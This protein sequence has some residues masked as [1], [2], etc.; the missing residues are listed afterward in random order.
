VTATIA[1]PIA[2]GL[3]RWRALF[4]GAIALIGALTVGGYL[5]EHA[6]TERAFHSGTVLRE[7]TDAQR[8]VWEAESAVR[9]QLLALDPTAR[10]RY[11]AAREAA[12]RH[13][14]ALDSLT[15]DNTDQQR[16]VGALRAAIDTWA[17]A[18]AVPTFQGESTAREIAIA[19]TAAFDD[20]TR[21]FDEVISVETELQLERIARRNRV[22]VIVLSVL[23]LALLGAAIAFAR[24]A[25]ALAAAAMRAR[26]SHQRAEEQASELQE[27]ASQ[28]EEQAA[29]LEEQ[30]AELE[31]RVQVADEANAQLEQ[32]AAFL[33]S[34]LDGAPMGI[35]FYDRDLRFL[36]INEALA[37]INGASAEAHIGRSIE[38]MV[39][40]IAP[41]VRP[42]IEHVLRTNTTASDVLVEGR[43]PGST[44]GSRRWLVTYYPILIG[45]RENKPMGVGCMVLDVTERSQLEAQ[46]RQAQKMEAVGR[47]AGGIA[48]DFNNVLTIIQ[49]YAELLQ[50]DLGDDGAGRAEVGA[51][52]SAADRATALA[53]QLLAFSRREVV[54][55]R[56]L[57]VNTVIRGMESILRRLLRQGITLELALDDAP[58]VVRIDAGQLE[59]VLMN[60][61]INAVDAMPNGG[62]LRIETAPRDHLPQADADRAAP[63]ALITVRDTG[64]GM[65]SEVQE[66]LFEPFFTTKPAGQGTGLGL[67]TTY[68][69]VHDAGGTIRLQSALGEGSTFDVFLPRAAAADP[70]PTRRETPVGGMPVARAGETLLLAED[71]PAIREALARMLRAAG[72]TVIEASNGGEA[73]R[74]AE[75]TPGRIDLLLTDVMM[76][77]VGGKELVQRLRSV[78]PETRV[79]LMSGY[80]DDEA[81]R[82]EL[83]D[84]RH[85]FLQK[86]FAAR[87]AVT[88][89]RELLDAP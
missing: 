74:R 12:R 67:A 40:A 86:P 4:I 48:H 55:P 15:A 7:L 10:E 42:I 45:G 61:A 2:L 46:L 47:L 70:E 78:R 20:V 39:P 79:I 13:L 58:L 21:L 23:L 25:G 50:S 41:T 71:E 64:T 76:P 80:T 87:K 81:L 5:I 44:S 77:G 68:A 35:A 56:D 85:V 59:Q 83:G 73:L 1:D 30:A 88:A 60:L 65:T 49:S 84:A 29:T 16:R 31:H 22:R 62:V 32:T 14:G 36:R 53:R 33:D 72:F 51:I 34:A 11:T 9:A 66:R 89:V 27:Q 3:Q 24:L 52:R 37:R 6:S 57:D 69:I 38:E 19:G 8:A 26:E 63:T 82:T 43:T 18:F 17:V 28:L 54:I 75:E